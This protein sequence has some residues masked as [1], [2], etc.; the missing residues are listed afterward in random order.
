M[1]R[2]NAAVCCSPCCFAFPYPPGRGNRWRRFPNPSL[3]ASSMKATAGRL[4]LSIGRRGASPAAISGKSWKRSGPDTPRASLRM[5][6]VSLDRDPGMAAAYLARSPL[7]Y[8][9]RIGDAELIKAR[10]GMPVPTT[11]L[12][13]RDGSVE[14]RACGRRFGK[15]AG[16]LR[17][18]DRAPLSAG[19]HRVSERGGLRRRKERVLGGMG[20]NVFP[21]VP[22]SLLRGQPSGKIDS[23][24][25]NA[26]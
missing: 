3:P 26:L 2:L 9:A 17:G 23:R 1:N 7:P 12:Y 21:R 22:G 13:R 10:S 6:A 18:A 4:C 16:A 8:P 19:R 14:R 5:L 20:R 24:W 11:I 15:A 25:R